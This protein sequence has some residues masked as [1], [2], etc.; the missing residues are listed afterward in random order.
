MQMCT[1]DLD[2]W[3]SFSPNKDERNLRDVE[4]IKRKEEIGSMML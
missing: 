4:H 2:T 1:V 3:T